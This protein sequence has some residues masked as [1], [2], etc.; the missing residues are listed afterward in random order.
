VDT[1][2]FGLRALIPFVAA[3][4][5]EL[6]QMSSD[7]AEGW[8][9]IVLPTAK[10]LPQRRLPDHDIDVDDLEA[11]KRAQTVVNQYVNLYKLGVRRKSTFASNSRGFFPK[12]RRT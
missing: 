3:S 6:R 4:A 10:V 5:F 7:P 11:F 9:S 8:H 12:S 1:E 2:I